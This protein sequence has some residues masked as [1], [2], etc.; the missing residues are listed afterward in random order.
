MFK[1]TL[2]ELSSDKIKTCVIREC[3]FIILN[4]VSSS[5]NRNISGFCLIALAKISTID[6]KM[7]AK[8]GHPY[9]MSLFGLKKALAGPLFVT[10]M[11][12]SLY[13]VLTHFRK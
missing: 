9:L 8:V 3:F 1:A 6:T 11:P 5:N 10:Q 13:R 4:S 2:R 12:I 7:F